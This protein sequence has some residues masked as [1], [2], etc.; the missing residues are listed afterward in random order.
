M[1][2]DQLTR[3]GV[4]ILIGLFAVVL[5]G[6]LYGLDWPG[7]GLVVQATQESAPLGLEQLVIAVLLVFRGYDTWLELVVLLIAVLG[8]ATL[9][10]GASLSQR[11][12]GIPAEPLLAA[13]TR[14]LL[15][16]VLL[17]VTY[18]GGFQGGT[19]AA[20]G[21][22]LWYLA[23]APIFAKAR[24]LFFRSLVVIAIFAP[25]FLTLGSLLRGLPLFSYPSA[26][27]VWI[28]ALDILVAISVTIMLAWL[29]LTA[30]PAPKTA[31][32][33]EPTE[34]NSL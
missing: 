33:S 30:E 16:L 19:I 3:A 8:T 5:L 13:F 21:L 4:V 34:S 26:V 9:L 18:I 12:I 27:A 29:T 28:P 14:L 10:R 15:P 20:A 24:G 25:L 1:L 6:S 11:H 22:V 23:G 31:N 32:D 2:S 7:P 17:A